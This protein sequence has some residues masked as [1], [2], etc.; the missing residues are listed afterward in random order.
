MAITLLLRV[1]RR[2][3]ALSLSALAPVFDAAACDRE[4]KEQARE[5]T[6]QE[7]EKEELQQRQQT[8]YY[9]EEFAGAPA[10]VE[11]P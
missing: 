4:P 2:R 5:E 3:F 1:V 6:T 9:G 11:K 8:S 10:V 7:E